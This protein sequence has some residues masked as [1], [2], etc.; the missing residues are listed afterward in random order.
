MHV[1]RVRELESLEVGV[2]DDG[3]RLAKV[4]D[5]L[6]AGHDLGPR[7][8]ADLVDELNGVLLAVVS[9]AVPYQHVK[10]ILVV[11]DVDDAIEC[12]AMKCLQ[13]VSHASYRMFIWS[14]NA[15]C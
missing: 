15:D 10:F 3:G 9:D 13:S 7:Y 2:R 12:M 6:E 8:A 11:L 5:L 1:H 14:R 4:L